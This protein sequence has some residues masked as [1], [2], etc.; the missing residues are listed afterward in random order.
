MYAIEFESTIEN[1]FIKV[2]VNHLANLAGKIKV[3]ILTEKAE[4][5][6]NFIDELLESPLKAENLTPLSREEIYESRK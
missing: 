5:T 2:P 1:G 4:K 3:I 6:S